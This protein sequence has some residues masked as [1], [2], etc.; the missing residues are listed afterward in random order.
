M[1]KPPSSYENSQVPSYEALQTSLRKLREKLA[2]LNQQLDHGDQTF[3]STPRTSREE[4]I[5]R[6][7]KSEILLEISGLERQ[8]WQVEN[9]MRKHY[10]VSPDP[11]VA[12]DA[13]YNPNTLGTNER[14]T[15]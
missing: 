6:T 15:G 1:E 2:S 5:A 9:D 13:I 11:H 8:I 12:N 4:S 7:V 14:R 10:A 3:A